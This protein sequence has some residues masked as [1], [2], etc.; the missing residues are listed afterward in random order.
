MPRI[1]DLYSALPAITGKLELEYEG[2]LKGG[3]AVAR[4]LIRAAVG[5][6]YDHYFEGV[7]VAQIIQWFDLGGTLKLDETADSATMVRQL[8]GIQGL[9]EKVKALGLGA[10]EPDALRASAA[11]FILEG[12]HAHRRISRNEERGFAAE[13]KRQPRENRANESKGETQRASGPNVPQAVQLRRPAPVKSIRYSRYTG[14]DLGIAAED[15]LQ[16]L[17]PISCWKAASTPSTRPSTSGTNTPSK[18]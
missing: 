2:E 6:V 9:M 13:E 15:L 4:E 14:E 17:S 8:G 11:E 16:A 7:N 1:L 10:N 12:L 18:I 3:D 5:K